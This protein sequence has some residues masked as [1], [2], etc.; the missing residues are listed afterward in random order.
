MEK[1]LEHSLYL[2]SIIFKSS[3]DNH[4]KSLYLQ[5]PVLHAYKLDH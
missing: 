3:I 4:I 1:N 2:I 5:I